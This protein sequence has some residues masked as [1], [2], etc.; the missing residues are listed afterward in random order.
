MVAFATSVIVALYVFGIGH[1]TFN[2]YR[3]LFSMIKLPFVLAI[4]MHVGKCI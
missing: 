3:S 2:M 1:Y 4:A